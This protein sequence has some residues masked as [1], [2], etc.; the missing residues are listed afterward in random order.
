VISLNLFV[1]KKSNYS[2]LLLLLSF[3]CCHSFIPVLQLSNSFHSHFF[4]IIQ[5][6]QRL[7]MVQ[8]KKNASVYEDDPDFD[9]DAPLPVTEEDMF[10]NLNGARLP[11]RLRKPTQFHDSS[12]SLPTKNNSKK[13]NT[14]KTAPLAN[15][16]RTNQSNS[17]SS[18]NSICKTKKRVRKK[19]SSTVSVPV[20]VPPSSVLQGNYI[21]LTMLYLSSIPVICFVF[22]LLTF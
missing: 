22:P 19:S 14:K 21:R 11:P 8:S 5:R 18:S 20:L 2:L 16:A 17:N 4:N 15:S 10:N 3:C 1:T 9:I 7:K 6:K 13:K 12:P